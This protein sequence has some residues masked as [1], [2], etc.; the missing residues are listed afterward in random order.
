MEGDFVGNWLGQ[1]HSFTE[2]LQASYDLNGAG[3][4]R[5]HLAK[6]KDR[7]SRAVFM[8]T[9]VFSKVIIR[10]YLRCK[11]DE[12]ELDKILEPAVL[13][14][15]FPGGME[16]LAA[17]KIQS[18]GD[19]SAISTAINKIPFSGYTQY[20]LR[21]LAGGWENG[22]NPNTTVLHAAK[23]IT[24]SAEFIAGIRLGLEN[25]TDEE[26]IAVG[27]GPNPGGIFGHNPEIIGDSINKLVE[28][29]KKK[30]RG[31]KPDNR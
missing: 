10:E 16:A 19:F 17:M 12:A 24:A 15:I 23:L 7:E 8:G 29:W 31:K 5:R 2:K 11:K 3:I 27:H 25:L 28:F 4:F 20:W 13:V 6:I 9:P 22:P 14:N 18:P 21:G 26:L 1:A 30:R